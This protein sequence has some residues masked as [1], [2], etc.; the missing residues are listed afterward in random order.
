MALLQ[1]GPSVKLHAG[2]DVMILCVI[3]LWVLLLWQQQ[4]PQEQNFGMK[5]G[6]RE[7]DTPAD[8]PSQI[9]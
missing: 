5:K 9:G 1:L 2:R 8:H 4:Q 6:A 3:I 7:M